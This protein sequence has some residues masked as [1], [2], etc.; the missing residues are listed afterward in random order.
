M[1]HEMYSKEGANMMFWFTAAGV[2][3]GGLGLMTQSDLFF[4]SGASFLF[5]GA[6]FLFVT[7]NKMLAYGK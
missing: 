3:L 7:M 1:L 5:I 2:V 6:I 4:K